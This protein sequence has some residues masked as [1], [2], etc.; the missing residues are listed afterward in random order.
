[1]LSEGVEGEAQVE[2][3]RNHNVYFVTK[4]VISQNDHFAKGLNP[5]DRMAF[6]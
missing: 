5:T 3:V 2:M 6:I 1:M 4:F